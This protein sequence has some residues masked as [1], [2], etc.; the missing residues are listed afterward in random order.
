MN[1]TAVDDAQRI[2]FYL[3][4]STNLDA[5]LTFINSFLKLLSVW[6]A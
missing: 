2:Y 4:K 6:F 3:E 1:A 5:K